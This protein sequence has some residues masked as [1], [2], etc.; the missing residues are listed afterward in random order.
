MD[1]CKLELMKIR[2][3]TY[4]WAAAGVLVSLVML[5]ILF[6]FLLQI[7]TASGGIPI[8]EE[9]DLFG[10]WSGLISLT[11]ALTF[12][13]FSVFA[14]VV[15]G[16]VI[17]SEYCGRNAVVLFCYPVGRKKILYAKS[18]IVCGITYFFAF[19]SNVLAAGFMYVTA[20]VFGIMPQMDMANFPLAVVLSGI[21]TGISATA[22][23][24]IC[25]VIG[26]QKKSVSASIVCSIIIVCCVTNFIAMTP[27]YFLVRLTSMSV[28]CLGIAAFM[29]HILENG[30]I[31]MEV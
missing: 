26:W 12:A 14:A 13:F 16:K 19:F 20:H 5:G 7:E 25:A 3:S 18:V 6:L 22:V 17:V 11:S 4:L 15:A 23:G 29:Y 24:M 31:D 9:V 28:I 2:L 27:A 30:I 21:L 8:P 1:L 10:S